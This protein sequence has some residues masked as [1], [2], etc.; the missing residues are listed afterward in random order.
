MSDLIKNTFCLFESITWY[1]NEHFVCNSEQNVHDFEQNIYN[2]EQNVHNFEQNVYNSE[3]N[4]HNFEQN[5][6]NSEQ[7]VYNSEILLKSWIL[8]QQF[9]A[10]LLVQSHCNQNFF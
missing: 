9:R 7:N 10:F 2:S 8:E 6:Y 4:V 5:V 1:I 3:Q